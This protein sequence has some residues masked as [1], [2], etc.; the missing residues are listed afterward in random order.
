M[1]RCDKINT[2]CTCMCAHVC[3]CVYACVKNIFLKMWLIIVFFLR[4]NTG[5]WLKIL[6]NRNYQM[7]SWNNIFTIIIL[8]FL[9]M[10]V[11]V[12]IRFCL[13]IHPF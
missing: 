13:C 10:F 7:R 5:Q 9:E 11:V 3:V 4:N 8:Y 2:V 12:C 6:I 1:G